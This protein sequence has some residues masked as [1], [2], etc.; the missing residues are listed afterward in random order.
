M[1][2][3]VLGGGIVG[4][5][6]ALFLARDGHEVAVIDR[7]PGVAMECSYANGGYVA[8]SQA[9]PWSAPGVPRKTLLGML[10][11]DPPILLH[12]RQL[13][14]I[15]RWGVEFL[16]CSRAQTSWQNTLHVLRLAIYSFDALKQA[17]GEA[18]IEYGAVA[19]GCLK[20]FSDRESLEKTIAV[21]EKQ[22]PF[23]LSYRTLTRAECIELA[24][25]LAPKADTLAG[26]I[27]FPDE[28]NGDCYAFARGAESWCRTRGVSF[29]FGAPVRALAHDGARITAV[30]TDAGTVQADAYV[31]A[32]GADSPLLVRPLGVR[33]PIVPI[34]GY[35][36]TLPRAAWP[37]APRLPVLDEKRKFGFAPLGADRLRFTGF[38]EL[39][40]YDTRPEARRAQAFVGAFTGLFPQLK[41]VF[42]AHAP[43]P[44]CCLR[45]VTP[46]GLPILG[47]S[48]YAN[49]W[50]NVG[51]G[52]LG[53]TLAH[54]CARI[55]AALIAGRDPGIDMTGYAPRPGM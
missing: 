23:G 8:V 4:V 34:K 6:T 55:L 28:E 9:V 2:V 47:R 35:S 51:Q 25:A 24:P 17:R 12:A 22:R 13:P 38:A 5:S 18:G 36:Y 31:L 30:V 7:Q 27:H 39:Q 42:A 20:V 10:R 33:L 19:R 44:F 1:K 46:S 41:P 21:S 11:P 26:G 14:N 53:W 3:V 43:A 29:L 49:L 15:W 54:G 45:P 48:R 50:Y 32:A 40:G 16:R 37:E 52:H